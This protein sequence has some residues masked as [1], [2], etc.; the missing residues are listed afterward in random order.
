LSITT[1]PCSLGGWSFS[2]GKFVQFHSKSSDL[3][4]ELGHI[5]VVNQM[6]GKT[7]LA[8]FSLKF[9]LSSMH[10]QLGKEI[11]YWCYVSILPPC[12]P[13]FGN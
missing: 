3:Q 13:T 12:L 9:P 2:H 8:S 4:N 1:N 5:N 6:V 10:F 11:I 7:L